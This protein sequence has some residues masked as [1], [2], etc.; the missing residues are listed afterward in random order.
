M[1]KPQGRF[2]IRL[3]KL[4]YGQARDK[5]VSQLNTAFIKGI[6]RVFVIHGIGEGKLKELTANVVKELNLG[7][8]VEQTMEYNPGVT[9]IDLNPPDPGKLKQYMKR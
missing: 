4:S 1:P 7:S 6:K 5:L 8:I 9:I 2:E 3:R